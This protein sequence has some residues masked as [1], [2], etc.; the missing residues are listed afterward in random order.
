MR[1]GF[2]PEASS[3]MRA[4][5]ESGERTSSGLGTVPGQ[6]EET[7]PLEEWRVCSRGGRSA[8]LDKKGRQDGRAGKVGGRLGDQRLKV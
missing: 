2:S 8:R 3:N 5:V 4:C 7:E 6:N 1:S